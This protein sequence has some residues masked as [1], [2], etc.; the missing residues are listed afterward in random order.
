MGKEEI[1]KALREKYTKLT[2]DDFKA[3]AGNR[4]AL[5]K[6]VAEK[7]GKSEDEAK[8]EVDEIFE[9]NA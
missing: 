8:K 4:E 2:P 9:T 1:Q 3:A 6:T 5:V 7:E